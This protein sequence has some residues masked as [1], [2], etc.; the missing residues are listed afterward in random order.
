[1]KELETDVVVIGGG[2]AGMA[3]ACSAAEHGARVVILEK[4]GSLGGS[5]NGG[6][7]LFAVESRLQKE[8]QLAF[9]TEDAFK[10]LMEFTHW[11][12]DARLVSDYIN[13]SASTIEWF[14]NMGIKFSDVVAYFVGA[15]Y[16]WH[17]KDPNSPNLTDAI[18]EKAK[19]F[20]TTIQLKTSVK[21]IV[22][23][24]SRVVGVIAEDEF[25]NEVQVSTKAVIIATGG[26]GGNAEWIKKYTGYEYGVDLFSFAFPEMQ[27]DGIKI[28]WEA[29]AGQSEM[30]VNTYISLPDP[31]GGPGGTGFELGSFRQPNLMVNLSGERFMNEETMRIPG[32]AGNAVHRQKNGC[33]FMIF[34]E[35]ANTHYDQGWDFVMSKL[36]ITKSDHL[37]DFIRKAQE[38]G[39]QHLFM[40]DSLEE[41]S[42]ATGIDLKGLQKTLAEYNHAA[43]IGRDEVFY[44]QAKYLRPIKQPKFYAARF[45]QGGYG[46]LGGIKIN[47]KTEVVTK[48][49]E[50]IAGLYAVG[51]DANAIYNGSYPFIIS[52]NVSSFCYNSG[53]IAGE[54]AAAYLK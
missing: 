21:K 32:F 19:Q 11:K 13:K 26:F 23:E 33:A 34:D 14:E 28:A 45:F 9:S 17:F 36:P 22:K 54:N 43:E 18:W 51:N 44:K 50:V 10:F 31:F 53:R 6:N 48:D 41:L 7:G 47:Y 29:G 37:G 35:S 16:T 38:E 27:G 46:T 42:T 8:K 20:G 40:A 24:K 25:G 52:G 5:V 39:Y 12:V 3:A 1:M 49:N 30:T 2:A 4:G 15:Q